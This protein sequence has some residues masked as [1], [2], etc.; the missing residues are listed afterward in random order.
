MIQ[1]AVPC[2]AQA[3]ILERRDSSSKLLLRAIVAIETEKVGRHVTLF[4]D[5]GNGRWQPDVREAHPR[6]PFGFLAYGT[7]VVTFPGLPVERLQSLEGVCV[8]VRTA[9]TALQSNSAAASSGC[10]S[11]LF[12]R[13]WKRAPEA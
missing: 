13:L 4:A 5:R 9:P 11:M 2:D 10:T 7:V 12:Y 1:D 8:P 3:S 6:I